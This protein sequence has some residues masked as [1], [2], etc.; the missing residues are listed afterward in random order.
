MCYHN[1]QLHI[2]SFISVWIS[3]VNLQCG[4]NFIDVTAVGEQEIIYR[5]T[6]S[7][8]LTQRGAD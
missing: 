4:E 7:V 3:N 2:F 1:N 6:S 8:Q 5:K